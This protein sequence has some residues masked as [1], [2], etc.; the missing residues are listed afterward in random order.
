MNQRPIMALAPLAGFTDH[1]FR[2]LVLALGADY[3]VTE[4]ISA[5]ALM[6]KVPRTLYMLKEIDR[7]PMTFVQLMGARP[8]VM[9]DAARIAVDLGA[10]GIDLNM[11]CPEKRIISQG[12]GASLLRNPDTAIEIS[13]KVVE[14]VSVPVT[15]KMRIGWAK[16]ETPKIRRLLKGLMDIG[17]SMVAIH[18]R[19]RQQMFSGDPDW[20]AVAEIIHGVSIPVIVNGS[21]TDRTTLKKALSITKAQG[22]MIGRGALASPW[23]FEILKMP[24]QHPA[25]SKMDLFQHYKEAILEHLD[26]IL[27]FHGKE[28]G[29]I[30]LRQHVSWYS[31]GLRDGARFRQWMY[32]CNS[33]PL[34]VARFR[35]LC[36]L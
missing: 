27:Q 31:K 5:E 28:H 9:V 30:C 18:G 22:I 15:V 25:L 3:A 19:T 8:G 21:I 2:R 6:R 7:E 29:L 26:S 17:I 10:R 34:I 13:R 24:D 11:G 23:I 4:M 1:P 35:E 33:A 36:H 14:N 12:A 32:G 16:G 20:N